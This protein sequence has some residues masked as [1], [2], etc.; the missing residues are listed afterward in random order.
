MVRR[1][2][3]SSADRPAAS[4]ESKLLTVNA[5]H[6]SRLAVRCA[7]R[8]DVRHGSQATG[9]SAVCDAVMEAFAQDPLSV[10]AMTIKWWTP[11]SA[12]RVCRQRSSHAE[13]A[14]MDRSHVHTGI[15]ASGDRARRRAAEANKPAASSV[16][17]RTIRCGRVDWR[18]THPC[19]QPTIQTAT[20]V[21]SSEQDLSKLRQAARRIRPCPHWSRLA[22][23]IR[24]TTTI[25]RRS[26]RRAQPAVA[27]E[28]KPQ[29]SPAC[30][31]RMASQSAT[32]TVSTHGLPTVAFATPSAAA[33]T[34]G[35]PSA[36]GAPVQ[37][38]V[39]WVCGCVRFAVAT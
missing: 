30:A 7:T 5:Q 21:R 27:V 1:R 9:A 13:E 31:T 4:K 23:P 38:S 14:A 39:V 2:E 17:C 33:C 10:S 19:A 11:P 37:C 3:K 26:G 34:N 29:P 16:A 18:T 8:S 20:R 24:V 35:T 22:T 36:T 32:P 6:R 12:S 15:A 28:C 25:G